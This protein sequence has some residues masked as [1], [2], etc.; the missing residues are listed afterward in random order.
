MKKRKRKKEETDKKEGRKKN[1]SDVVNRP[2]L[3]IRNTFMHLYSDLPIH[4]SQTDI[5]MHT[6]L[7]H[8]RAYARYTQRFIYTCLSAAHL[9]FSR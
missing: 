2:D 8:S 5:H 6:Q 4:F 7:P 1:K 9:T 3:L